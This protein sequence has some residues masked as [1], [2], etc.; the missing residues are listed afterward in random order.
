LAIA[1][2]HRNSP[3]RPRSV[4]ASAGRSAGPALIKNSHRPLQIIF[5]LF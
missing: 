3:D 5:P 4:V 1:C 2:S